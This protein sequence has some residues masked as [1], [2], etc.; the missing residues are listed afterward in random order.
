MTLEI[1]GRS[2]N[3]GDLAK[4]RINL[5]DCRDS[6]ETFTFKYS[7]G[8][9]S[10]AG[11]KLYI[12][13]GDNC[14][15]S[16]CGYRSYD[17]LAD[18]GKVKIGALNLVLGDDATTADCSGADGSINVWAALLSGT[19]Q[20]DKDAGDWS[21]PVEIEYDL[22]PPDA[23][24]GITAGFGEQSV[25]VEWSVG[26]EAANDAGTGSGEGYSGFDI[27]CWPAPGA[28][29]K[30]LPWNRALPAD[31]G[32]DGNADSGADSDA[33]SD[34]DSDTDTGNGAADCGSAGGF[35]AGD[36]YDDQYVCK[37][38]G[39][40]D[41]TAD[42]GGLTNGVEYR[43]GVVALDEFKNPSVVSEAA[44]AIPAEVIDFSEA[45]KSAG[46]TGSGHYCFV[47]T[48]AFGSYDHPVVRVL[49]VFRD[50]FLE[51]L[52]GGRLAIDGYYAVGP[53]LASALAA[54]PAALVA[55]RDALFAASGLALLLLSIGPKAATAA[56][57]LSLALGLVVGLRLNRRGRRT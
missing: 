26:D 21:D 49:R 20:E 29:A 30:S 33:D 34:S 47:A 40:T 5:A 24:S 28:A 3:L 12:F 18:T 9:Q 50:G 2:A 16:E 37:E 41:R 31:G 1:Y 43:F 38:M 4:N 6:S 23:P 51:K 19:T 56:V 27:L 35:V 55:T 54:H 44:C 32:P 10:T 36:A 45:Y 13:A 11:K 7:L 42:V 52:P 46:G 48:A 53:R 39:R 14:D 17:S 8:G 25:T 57:A 15:T 22:V